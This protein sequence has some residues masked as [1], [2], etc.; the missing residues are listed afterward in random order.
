MNSTLYI[1]INKRP[2]PIDP[3]PYKQKRHIYGYFTGT[4]KK[5][6]TGQGQCLG[7]GL[8][9]DGL[10][11]GAVCRNDNINYYTRLIIWEVLSFGIYMCF[12]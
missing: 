11:G 5:N 2:A 12:E 9:G 7:F 6:R 4:A 10:K 8:F 1:L 3:A